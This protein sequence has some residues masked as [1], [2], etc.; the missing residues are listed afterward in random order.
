MEIRYRK[1]FEREYRKLPLSIQ[2]IAEK[3]VALFQKNPFD[4][5]LRTHKLHGELEGFQAFW[6]DFRYRIIF[7]FTDKRDAELYSI[8]D[9]DIYE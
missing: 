8:G 9:H 7:T 2:Q 4:S 5:R 3:R 1:R 6:I